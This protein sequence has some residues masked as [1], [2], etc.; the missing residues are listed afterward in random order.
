[1]IGAAVLRAREGCMRK[2]IY[3]LMTS[4]VS[5]S[6]RMADVLFDTACLMLKKGEERK[7]V[8]DVEI[9]GEVHTSFR[10]QQFGS[11]GGVEFHATIETEFGTGNVKYIVRQADAE[12]R[13]KLEWAPFFSIEDLMEEVESP[14]SRMAPMYN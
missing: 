6:R 7:R 11:I 9:E 2:D 4:G 3:C 14:P 1:M 10:D 8:N 13:N 12:M 5:L